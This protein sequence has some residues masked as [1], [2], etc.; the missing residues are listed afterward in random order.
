MILNA[1]CIDC[2]EPTKFVAGFLMERMEATVAFTTA[3]TKM[4]NK[5]NKGNICV[6]GSARKIESTACQR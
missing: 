1:K 4:R 6:K 5:A 2:K 3:I